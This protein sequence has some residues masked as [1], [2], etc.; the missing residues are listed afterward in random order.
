MLGDKIIGDTMVGGKTLGGKMLPTPRKHARFNR[1][2]HFQHTN[3]KKLPA[4]P[5]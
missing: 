4:A 3:L 5:I 2:D 1:I